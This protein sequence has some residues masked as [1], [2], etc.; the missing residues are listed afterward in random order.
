MSSS[1]STLLVPQDFFRSCLWRPEFIYMN[2]EVVT[3]KHDD[4]VLV[5][6]DK[7]SNRTVV[8]FVT[9]VDVRFNCD[10]DFGRYPF[11]AQVSSI[12]YSATHWHHDDV[13]E[14]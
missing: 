8:Q 4:H 12:Y 5:G 1:L 6:K 3:W 7:A 11:D 9:S 13:K 14:C 2:G 10:M